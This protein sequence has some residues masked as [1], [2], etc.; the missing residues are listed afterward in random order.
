MGNSKSGD[1]EEKQQ[2]NDML[3]VMLRMLISN[4]HVLGTELLSLVIAW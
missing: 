2:V 1:Q 4:S 3:Q